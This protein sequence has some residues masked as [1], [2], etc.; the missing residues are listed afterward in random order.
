MCDKCFEIA[1]SK[2]SN[3]ESGTASSVRIATNEKQ[4]TDRKLE[5]EGLTSS[6]SRRLPINVYLASDWL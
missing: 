5:G 2:G 6:D 3:I 4:N 1:G